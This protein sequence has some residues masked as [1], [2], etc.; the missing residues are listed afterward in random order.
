MHAVLAGRPLVALTGAGLSTD[1]GIPDYR[2][3]GSPRATPMTYQQFRSSAHARRRYWARSHLGWTRVC[4]AAPNAGHRALVGLERA[5]VLRGLITQNVDGLHRGA[6]QRRVVDLHGRLSDVICLDCRRVSGRAALARRLA[7]LNPDFE[8]ADADAVTSAPDGDAALES[9]QG[10]V[11]ADCT[12]CGGVLKPDVVFFGENV[13][14]ERVGLCHAM[15]E[16]LG[17]ESGALLV[18][19]SSLTVQSGL[20]FV[21]RAAQRGIPVV[22]VNRGTTRADELATAKVDGGCSEVLATLV[23]GAQRCSVAEDR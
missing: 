21:R 19:G 5:G 4:R 1:S 12:S 14:A 6:G 16:S 22:I 2:G 13:P 7:E 17:V 18:A 20:R 3:P 11:V 9:V 10:F 8:H 15:V 23:G